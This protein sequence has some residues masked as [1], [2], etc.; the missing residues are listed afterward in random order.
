M[1]VHNTD[2][3]CCTLLF[4]A[5]IAWSRWDYTGGHLLLPAGERRRLLQSSAPW[6]IAFA[7]WI[8]TAE[9][10]K[11]TA[12]RLSSLIT[13][14]RLWRPPTFRQTEAFSRRQTRIFLFSLMFLSPTPWF[15]FIIALLLQNLGKLHVDFFYLFAIYP[16]SSVSGEMLVLILGTLWHLN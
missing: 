11:E 15:M 5:V 12:P 7:R 16:H 10:A 13:G 6:S 8:K 4:P 2:Y 14:R 1:A 9:S 3:L